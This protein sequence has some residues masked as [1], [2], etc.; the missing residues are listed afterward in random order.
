LNGVAEVIDPTLYSNL[1]TSFNGISSFTRALLNSTLYSSSEIPFDEAINVLTGLSEAVKKIEFNPFYI[2]ALESLLESIR[3]LRSKDDGSFYTAIGK[4]RVYLG[5]S[6][7]SAYIPDYP[8]D[9]TSEPRL[10]VDLLNNHKQV[11]VD[12]IEVRKSIEKVYTGNSTNAI[13]EQISRELDE[14]H[15][16]LA[17]SATIFSLRPKNSM[18]DEIFVDL[19]YLQKS[20]LD[21]NVEQLLIDLQ[22]NGVESVLQR[23]SVLQGNALQFLDRVQAK[24]PLYR[25]ILQPLTIAVND[26]KFGLGI[27]TV[28]V[29]QSATDK[30]LSSVIELLIRDPDVSHH[31]YDMDW[32]I[33][34]TPDKLAQLKSVIFERAPTSRKWAFY[35][36]L[37]IVILQ[38][39]TMGIHTNGYVN[40]H[41]L[42]SVNIVFNEIIQVW[43]AA[44]EY[45]RK[46]E[47]EKESLFKT[48]AKKYEP[49][50]DEELEEEDLKKI[51]ADFNQDFEDLN[52]DDNEPSKP[53]DSVPK[54]VEEL[55][56]LD[57]EDIYRIGHLHHLLFN[58]YHI[59]KCVRNNKSWD[60][61]TLQSYTAAGQL[62]SM[63]QSAFMN[64]TDRICK[65][66]HLN[67]TSLVIQRLEAENSFA[68]TSDNIYDFY[69]SENVGE[70][71]RV[72]PIVHRFKARV[73]DLIKEWPEH[74]ILEQL[75]VICD[76]LL[77]FSILSPV[78][79]FLTGVELL[80]QKSE[81]WEAYAAKHVSL[82]DQREELISLIVS[83]RQLELN[84][85]PKLLAA[86]EQYSQDAAFNWWFHLYDTV[87][88]TS[89]ETDSDEENVR[90]T[91]E[92]LGALDQFIQ[93]ATIIE[94]EPRLQMLDTFYKQT[95]LQSQLSTFE[96]EK[97]NYERTATI[98]H[99]VYLY[100]AQFREH[101]QTMLTQLRKPIEKD[102][103][104]F[105][106]I[107][108][109][110][111]V[112]I[113]ALRQSASKTHRQLHKCIRKY[114]EVLANSMLTVIAN[115][116]EEHAM[117][118]YG[119]DRKYQKDINHGLIDQLSQPQF[120]LTKTEV[121]TF[122]E[123]SWTPP[124]QY[125]SNLPL[126]LNRLRT[127]CRNDIFVADKE[128]QKLPLEAFMTE[129]IE[130]IKYFQKE[131]PSILTEENKKQVTNQK[132]IKKKALVDFLKELR[133]LGLKSRPSNMKELNSDTSLL[134][135]QNAASLETLL[136]DNTVSK[137]LS[138]QWTKAN[139]YYFRCIARLT[140][141][142]TVST[143]QV[144]RD[145]SML[146]VERS[147]AAT[148]HMFTLVNKERQVLSKLERGM[149]ILKGTCVQ[150]GSLFT[151]LQGGFSLVN[152]ESLGLRL[153]QHKIHVDQVT[154]L[155]QQALKLIKLQTI[156]SQATDDMVNVCQRL[157][158]IQKIVDG[159]FVNRYLY[160]RTNTGFALL[161]DD[162]A[163]TLDD[164]DVELASMQDVLARIMSSAPQTSHILYP[165]I[166]FIQRRRVQQTQVE[167]DVPN[168]DELRDKIY[169]LIDVTLVAIQ[170][171]KKLNTVEEK[172]QVDD[173]EDKEENGMG[174]DF[175]RLQSHKQTEFNTALH[176]ETAAK[177][178][179]DI[180]SLT[181]QLASSQVDQDITSLL[182]QLYP[183]VQQYL[184]VAQH[185]LGRMIMHHKSMSKLTYCLVNS[186]SIII[187]KGFCMPEGM[188]DGEEGDADGT[189]T[190][191]GVGEGQ[192][193]K[194]VSEQI[195]D[196]EQVL[197]TQNE[198]RSKDDKQDT[199]EEKN[200]MDMEN[201]FDGNLED[202]EQD[203]KDEQD[204][205]SSDS[206]DEDPDEQIGDVDDMD[207][208][209]VDDKMWGD[210]AEE[211]L[212][213]SDKT[214]DQGKQQEQQQE[215]E[216]V[217]KEDNEDQPDSKGEKPDNANEVPNQQEGE[218][219]E[220]DGDEMDE[221]GNDENDDDGMGED[222]DDI[223]NRPGEQMNAE[224]P[225]AET[226]ELPD[227]LEMDGDD[228]NDD[229]QDQ[230]EDQM[231]D[232][233][234]VEEQQQEK[235][236]EEENPEEEQGG[237][238]FH[239]ALDDPEQGPNEDEEMADAAA[240]MDTEQGEGDEDQGDGGDEDEEKEEEAAQE[241][242]DSEQQQ[243]GG[244]MEE[245]DEQDA[246]E[247]TKAQ[248]REQPN[249]D[250]A[251]D[252]QFGVQ[253]EAGKQS[254]S[255]AGKK[256]GEDDSADAEDA[257]AEVDKNEKKEQKGKAERGANQ[258]N[259]D[260]DKNEDEESNEQEDSEKPQSNPQ[261][262]LGDALENWRR[263]LADLEDG[264]EDEQVDKEEKTEDENAEDVKVNEEDTFEYIKNDE[265]A[266][267][268]Q[269]MGNAQPD[270]IQDVKMAGMDEQ[271]ENDKETSGEMHEDETMDDTVD[272]MPLP[273]D[274]LDT[275]AGAE[276]N[277]GAILSKKLPQSQLIDET[278]ILTM[279]ESVVAREPLEQ[280]DIERMRDELE[281]QVADWREEGRDINKARELWQGYEN[282]THDLAMG[283]CEQLRL[284]L[285]PTLATKLKGDYRTGKR[286]NMKKIIPYIASQF[287][288]DKIW[289][290]RTK[291]SKRQYQ[292]MISIDD[293]KSMSESHSVQLAYEA[294]S[295]ISKALSQLEVGDISITSF[296]ERVR[297][298]HPFDQPFTSESGA[299]VIQQFTFAQQ[300]T[301]V[302]K[303]V[304]STISLFENAKH[305]SGPG[306]AEL[307][308]LQLILSDGICEDH[309]SLRSLVRSAL[310]QQIMIIFIVVDNKPEKES[311]MNMNSVKYVQ[312]NGKLALEMN[313]YLDTF[314][315][316][317]F[318]ILRDINSLPE[319]LSD[320][321]RQYFSFVSA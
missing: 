239:D 4:S 247:E 107:A 121:P 176:V 253:G 261:R 104:D 241:V 195:E 260:D 227:D 209:A 169:G 66:G 256:E 71:K 85:W 62:A 111:D 229:N 236:Q 90:K 60:R 234:D 34:A 226:L 75:V 16:E 300:K 114:R 307:W 295:L 113:Y 96:A 225:E 294:L 230:G 124:K 100:Y 130:Q 249:D 32:H 163:S 175:I 265:D 263:R 80:L 224:I 238:A 184:M 14:V 299:S 46:M 106:K 123:Q 198:E 165:I 91:H 321:L 268:M 55:S 204:S 286:L 312:K 271:E 192:G 8:V 48:R 138:E 269:T 112:N 141:L 306:N 231:F 1:S 157:G 317:Y 70:A 228:N 168:K 22:D 203:E 255:S 314:P 127:Y 108:T 24:F 93:T 154:H 285:E 292:V 302:N 119:D 69:Q 200:G 211:N 194:D 193:D 304:E 215:S 38:R 37:L 64:G 305:S 63:A 10:R 143:T 25:D 152:D 257:D 51:F 264:D 240:Q 29:R 19:R 221:E 277:Q 267:D 250:T 287:K 219:D 162:V 99:N 309:E 293:S 308:Q 97:V 132:L 210:D 84:C 207:P 187:T 147:M 266:H 115:Y 280:Q 284:I 185:T 21:R 190:G 58:A 248:N 182:Q 27:L 45:K 252:N 72:E 274:N 311:I 202:I 76:R 298:L 170:D 303:L 28:H 128:S 6:F 259:D 78:A 149:T 223:D 160:P 278:E 134:F 320:A 54:D 9:P 153:T 289:L 77:T 12:N 43:K 145:L 156:Q 67:V 150:L 217:G 206:E 296:G 49:R 189:M 245:D 103:K 118:Q 144:S 122:E 15:G 83:W 201:D 52:L 53:K 197:G 186:F 57:D 102:L 297:L 110:K 199:K 167:S 142:R 136:S 180:L 47:A 275:A 283:L 129:M 237:E 101:A 161:S 73:L 139:D 220:G 213:E 179:L 233:M 20:M 35:L 146:E 316:Q 188:D 33:L 126:T 172:P 216:I 242:G 178:C 92:L 117:Y 44:E 315:F 95:K 50:T 18:L 116:N 26:I 251:A 2:A 82:K 158:Q 86:Q 318:M 288:K 291:P 135:R 11:L 56:V 74:A 212:N 61:E 89:F 23:E 208:D 94:F 196:E 164:H 181:N 310:D 276:D 177:R 42:I 166:Q 282:L 40:E 290:R 301:Y 214:V 3:F 98:L 5:L 133:R 262:S 120:W 232:P 279:D 105:V 36:R 148:E 243:K 254:K 171:L 13:V 222:E 246:D 272:T 125:L 137:E 41:D 87:N 235:E 59:D 258:A 7:V 218:G 174:D 191:T 151:A 140:H 273:R 183:F 205:E 131:T 313:S 173:E 319:A 244:M 17:R 270:Q 88:N 68:M 39:L 79:K 109:W 281:T 30:F 159:L 81:D 65:A 31:V 155:T